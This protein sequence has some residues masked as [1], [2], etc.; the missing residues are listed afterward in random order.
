MGRQFHN[1]QPVGRPY[2]QGR[3]LANFQLLTHLTHT[4]TAG[5]KTR[6][7]GGVGELL[8]LFWRTEARVTAIVAL[9][10]WPTGSRTII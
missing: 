3:L 10:L 2:W 6:L 4:F 1:D 8:L 9:E 7:K 5:E